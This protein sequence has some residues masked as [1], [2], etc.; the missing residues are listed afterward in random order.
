MKNQADPVMKK[1]LEVMAE[2]A[3]EVK[4]LKIPETCDS[5]DVRLI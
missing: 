1:E 5:L 4:V 3:D 2:E